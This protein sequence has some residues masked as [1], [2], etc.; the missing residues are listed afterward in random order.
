MLCPTNACSVTGAESRRSH[1]KFKPL[2]NKNLTKNKSAIHTVPVTTEAQG[3]FLDFL[4]FIRGRMRGY[5]LFKEKK[6]ASETSIGPCLPGLP[7]TASG[8]AFLAPLP[9]SLVCPLPPYSTK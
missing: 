6:K 7:V 2:S 9:G 8:A 3:D 4:Y 5:K 1:K